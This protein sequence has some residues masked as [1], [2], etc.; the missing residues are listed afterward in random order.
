MAFDAGNFPTQIA[1]LAVGEKLTKQRIRQV[2]EF[3]RDELR[4][5]KM[6]HR[7]RNSAVDDYFGMSISPYGRLPYPRAFNMNTYRHTAKC[8]DG[9]CGTVACIGG[10]ADVA[11]GDSSAHNEMTAVYPSLYRLFT[12]SFKTNEVEAY[13]KI[14]PTQAAAAIDNWLKDGLPRWRKVIKEVA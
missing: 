13:N 8:E 4:A 5:G 9:T 1:P 7:Q 11:L 2:L 12:P 3:V 10:W 14:T 6:K